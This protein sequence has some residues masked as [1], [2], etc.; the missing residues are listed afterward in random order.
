MIL[1]GAVADHH[2]PARVISVCGAVGAVLALLITLNWVRDRG[3][4]SERHQRT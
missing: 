1:A 2:S 3:Q 4:L